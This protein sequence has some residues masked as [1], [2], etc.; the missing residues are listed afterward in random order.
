MQARVPI[1]GVSVCV[2]IELKT[3]HIY[4]VVLQTINIVA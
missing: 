3:R 1:G 4:K 2:V